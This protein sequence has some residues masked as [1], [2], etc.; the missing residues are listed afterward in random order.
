MLHKWAQSGHHLHSSGTQTT[1]CKWWRPVDAQ[2]LV[3]QVGLRVVCRHLD[4]FRRIPAHRHTVIWSISL[5]SLELVSRS[6]FN[7]VFQAPPQPLYTTWRALQDWSQH[8]SRLQRCCSPMLLIPTPHGQTHPR[9]ILHYGPAIME[10]GR[11]IGSLA[12][13]NP[14]KIL[15]C[16]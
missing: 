16:C 10:L 2:L 15:H 9:D 5:L 14:E 13:Y 1:S 7:V 3:K 8:L 4:T 12:G 6:I 11:D